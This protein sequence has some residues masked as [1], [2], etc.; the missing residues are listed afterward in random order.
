MKKIFYFLFA[1]TLYACGTK[2]NEVTTTTEEHSASDSLAFWWKHHDSINHVL[3]MTA[4]PLWQFGRQGQDLYDWDYQMEWYNG[5]RTVLIHTYD[6]IHPG[7]SGTDKDL[8]MLEEIIQFFQTRPDYSTMGMIIAYD[9]EEKFV[10]YKVIRHSKAIADTR[11]G[12]CF[13]KEIKAWNDL[14]RLLNKFT[15]NM[16]C[17]GWWCGSG[18]GPACTA[19]ACN[20]TNQRLG[21]VERLDK[22]YHYDLPLSQLLCTDTSNLQFENAVDAVL[23]KRKLTPEIREWYTEYQIEGYIREYNEAAACRDSLIDVFNHWISIR[24]ALLGFDNKTKQDT[25]TAIVR[26]IILISGED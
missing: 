14:Q 15:L 8:L 12:L 1:L 5:C 13:L 17:L 19:L 11:K 23:E 25:M 9:L 18:A 2:S 10:K 21:D 16:M 20:I 3:V 26:K 4:D 24:Q 6:S 22:F 7:V